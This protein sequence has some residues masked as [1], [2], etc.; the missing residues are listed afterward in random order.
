MAMNPAKKGSSRVFTIEG[1]ARPD[2]AP[3]YR[4][5]LRAGPQDWSLGDVTKI[6]CPDPDAYGKFIQVGEIQGAIG[7]PTSDLQGRYSL[8]EESY[9]MRIAVSRCALDYHV[10]YGECSDPSEFN[11]FTKAK[12][13]VNAL[14]SNHSTDEEGT[15]GSDG[16]GAINETVAVS[17]EEVY[18]ILPLSFAERGGDAVVNPIVDVVICDTASCGDCDEESDGC[19]KIYAVDNGITGSPGTAPDV[20]YSV[21]K[22][23][24]WAAEDVNSL[25]SGEAADGIA[26]VGIY[27][28]V[29]SNADGGIHYKQKSL[30]GDGATNWTRQATGI[31]VTGEPNDIWSVGNYAFIVGDLG[32]VYGTE[33][34]AAGVTVL[35]A[36]V[37]TAENLTAVHALSDQFAVAVGENDAIIF[38]E[39]QTTWATATATGG[40]NNLLC[41][42]IK[43]EKE[44]WV[45]DDAGGLYYTLDKG[46]TWTAKA[47]PGTGWTEVQDIQFPRPGV[48]YI[49]ADKSATPR[50]YSLR[51]FDG[52]YSWNVVPQ[53]GALPLADSLV[54]LATCSEDINFVVE[55]GTGDDAADGVIIVGQD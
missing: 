2:H 44:W 29:I 18:E 10:H 33:D 26:C 24:N 11:T 1:R 21:D 49:V 14:F 5:C 52:G 48:G 27:V 32:Y 46:V 43:N 3:V 28:V 34:P 12:V 40:G 30:L 38:T 20:I 19:E 39:N 36:G 50:A 51:S 6:E 54:A 16:E 13:Y 8:D 42:W 37:A 53:Y 31:V 9:L 41:I 15:L 55:V 17:A 4:S 45:G 25:A 23:A 35:D 22:G 7:R 47:L